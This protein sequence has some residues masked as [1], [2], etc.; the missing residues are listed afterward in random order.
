MRKL[1]LKKDSEL[2]NIVA[3]AADLVTSRYKGNEM[4]HIAVAGGLVRDKEYTRSLFGAYA[5]IDTYTRYGLRDGRNVLLGAVM[6]EDGRQW[7]HVTYKES[8]RGEPVTTIYT[9]D[10]A[11]DGISYFNSLAENISY[12]IES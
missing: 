7:I 4:T 10:E 8:P 6:L 5:L 11:L 3:I 2:R 1:S 12:D 9:V